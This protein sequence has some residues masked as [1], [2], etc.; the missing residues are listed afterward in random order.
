VSSENSNTYIYSYNIS[1]K[2]PVNEEYSFTVSLD[3]TKRA[4]DT[5]CYTYHVDRVEKGNRD[6]IEGYMKGFYGAGEGEPICSETHPDELTPIYHLVGADI[7]TTEMRTGDGYS[8]RYSYRDGVLVN[9]EYEYTAS[10][11]GRRVPVDLDIRFLG[12]STPSTQ[13]NNV[14]TKTTGTPPAPRA[15]MLSSRNVSSITYR[16]VWEI[17]GIDPATNQANGTSVYEY[18]IR[19]D[20]TGRKSNGDACVA[21]SIL[22]VKQGSMEDARELTAQL[23]GYQAGEKVCINI[24]SD[25]VKQVPYFLLDPSI[26]G[27]RPIKGENLSGEIGVQNG[28][29]LSLTINTVNQLLDENG[30]TV[31]SAPV[32]V[33]LSAVTMK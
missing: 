2:D 6:F 15:H 7:T 33:H 29:V 31:A 14:E 8:Y 28:I 20:V 23:L 9:L 1:L 30:N 25:D 24:Y 11:Q 27:N 32:S 21:Y 18:S 17:T 26:T 3:V 16:V 5:I 10:D 12:T 4:P 19:V 22:N 13:A